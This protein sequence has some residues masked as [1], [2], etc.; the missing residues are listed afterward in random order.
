MSMH[1][2][3]DS[4]SSKTDW[5]LCHKDQIQFR[6]E[7]IGFNPYYYSSDVLEQ[8]IQS[9]L[10][11]AVSQE[12]VTHIYFYG[13]GCST[14]QNQKIIIDALKPGFKNASIH[15]FHDLLGAARSLFSNKKGI[16]GIL[17]TGA[18]SGLYDGVEVIDNVPSLGYFFGDDGSGSNLGKRLI[19]D[20]LKGNMPDQ[21]KKEFDQ[22]FGYSFDY[23]L[24]QIYAEVGPVKFLASFGPFIHKHIES[25]YLRSLVI[26]AFSDFFE[27]NICKYRDF[28]KL[29]IKFIGSIALIFEDIL[30]EVALSFDCHIES[31]E[32][33]PM[34]GL[35][36]FH[37]ESGK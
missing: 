10:L 23:I 15:I 19:N 36:K 29:P 30:K 31:V 21:I 26:S 4:G 16:A 35:I 18:N 7:T 11:P 6:F 28:N 34:D 1:I 32:K 24:S 37:A 17:G 14:K 20:Y 22:H 8:I 5:V 25:D 2:I 33:Y 27:L 9:K 13:S 3:A 12:K